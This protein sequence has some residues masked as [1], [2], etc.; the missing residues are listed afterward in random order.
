M[1]RPFLRLAALV[2][3]AFATTSIAAPVPGGSILVSQSGNGSGT[4][5]STGAQASV[6]VF[7]TNGKEQFTIQIPTGSLQIQGTQGGRLALSPDGKFV[8]LAGYLPPFSGSGDLNTRNDS[9]APRGYVSINAK[10]GG[11]SAP[12]KV[13]N[14]DQES[15]D[16]VVTDDD[17][18]WLAGGDDLV[19]WKGKTDVVFNQGTFL[20]TILPKGIRAFDGDLYLAGLRPNFFGFVANFNGFP[21]GDSDHPR[22]LFDVTNPEDFAVTDNG[23]TIYV[24]RSEGVVDVYQK[25]KKW[26]VKYRLTAGNTALHGVALD[27]SGENPVVYAIDS[28]R[29]WKVVDKGVN[30]NFKRIAGVKAGH[31]FLGIVVTPG[32]GAPQV[33]V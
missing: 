29:L 9:D 23:N 2:A 16:T 30:A 3:T 31:A 22:V 33:K 15:A 19:Y 11:V 6:R 10:N 12:T 1:L 5:P 14:Q 24:A 28:N 17:R 13:R 32:G 26:S 20:N 8:G 27:L 7:Q 18:A 4:P 25:D 21:H